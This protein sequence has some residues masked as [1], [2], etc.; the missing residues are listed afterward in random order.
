ML[1]PT[2]PSP[3]VCRQKKSISDGLVWCEEIFCGAVDSRVIDD[4]ICDPTDGSKFLKAD[5]RSRRL[6]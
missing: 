2:R 1:V 6:G 4:I 3:V 5:R